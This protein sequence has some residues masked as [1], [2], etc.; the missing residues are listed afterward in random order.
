MSLKPA[1]ASLIAAS[2][3]EAWAE[4]MWVAWCR[5]GLCPDSKL[6]GK[7][8][9]SISCHTYVVA[10][11]RYS[12]HHHH[13]AC[14]VSE[15]TWPHR[16]R[17]SLASVFGGINIWLGA[18]VE[19]LC[20]VVVQGLAWL[21]CSKF[22]GV[23]INFHGLGMWAGAFVEGVCSGIVVQGFQLQW[24]FFPGEAS[25]STSLDPRL[26]LWQHTTS[27][28]HTSHCTSA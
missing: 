27:A 7:S 28:L 20:W 15:I 1:W 2:I 25:R 11:H 5:N 18:F 26:S 14:T 10:S 3:L 19:G 21:Q 6:E 23:N 12:C 4:D 17:L 24:F 16:F 8:L 9:H 13:L 22:W